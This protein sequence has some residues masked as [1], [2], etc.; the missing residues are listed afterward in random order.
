V[1]ILITNFLTPEYSRIYYKTLSWWNCAVPDCKLYT[2]SEICENWPFDYNISRLKNKCLDVAKKLKPDWMILMPGIDSA[3]K[4]CPNFNTLDKNKI[5]YGHRVDNKLNNKQVASI[6][7]YSN[8]VYENYRYDERHAFYYDDL[9]FFFL[10]TKTVA[11]EKLDSLI[12]VHLDHEILPIKNEFVNNSFEKSKKIFEEDY[13]K[14][15]NSFF[16]FGS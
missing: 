9:D 1:K 12:C 8:L 5:Y 6:H 13:K 7:L 3:I 16:S 14:E 15:Y 4:S 10:K 2:V 11:K